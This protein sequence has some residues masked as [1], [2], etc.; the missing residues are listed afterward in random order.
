M[1]A[2][3]E[4]LKSERDRLG[5]S[6]LEMCALTG[7]SRKTQFNYEN[8]ERFPDALYL[9]TLMKKGL[10]V[11]YVLSGD[12]MEE[13]HAASTTPIDEELLSQIIEGME[14]LLTKMHKSLSAGKKARAIVML[15]RSF[16]SQQHIDSDTIRQVIELAA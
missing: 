6:Q 16:S 13:A 11:L 10:D 15:Y 9:E 8:G 1:Q 14:L 3:G 5:L 7:V 12:R 4:R 2:I